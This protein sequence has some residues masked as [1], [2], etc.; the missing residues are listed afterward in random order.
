MAT[1]K[2]DI[3]SQLSE[4]SSNWHTKKIAVCRVYSVC[5][6]ILGGKTDFFSFFVQHIIL[7]NHQV[8]VPQAADNCNNNSVGYIA[9]SNSG[10]TGYTAISTR[11][12]CEEYCRFSPVLRV[13]EVLL[14]MN[15]CGAESIIMNR[16]VLCSW[17]LY[18]WC[19]RHLPAGKNRNISEPARRSHF[20][21]QAISNELLQRTSCTTTPW[22]IQRDHY[23]HYFNKCM[24]TQVFIHS[25]TVP[26]LD[27]LL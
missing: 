12:Y 13:R 6:Y 10:S 1:N 9:P 8:Q 20:L 18:Q 14:H 15:A 21:C 2:N 26:I 23:H 4:C 22:P 3:I 5:T 7:Q 27:V 17:F 25:I 16:Q 24:L 19:Y 11:Q